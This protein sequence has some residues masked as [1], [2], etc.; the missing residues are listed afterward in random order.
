MAHDAWRMTHDSSRIPTGGATM[1]AEPEHLRH[2]LNELRRTLRWLRSLTPDGPRY[3]LWLGDMVEFARVAFGADS[4][5]VARVRGVLLDRPRVPDD[6]D[7]AVQVQEYLSRLDAFAEVLAGFE[8]ALPPVV[9]LITFDPGP[10]PNGA[11]SP[12]RPD[13]S[14]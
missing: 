1:P 14:A 8:S 6:A 11:S 7:D 4:E 12:E 5:E 13:A 3:K 10:D 9:T 2:H